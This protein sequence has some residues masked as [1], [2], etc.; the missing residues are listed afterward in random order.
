M[1][2]AELELVA[3]VDVDAL[4][5]DA[6]ESIV[7]SAPRPVAGGIILLDDV[8]DKAQDIWGAV[9][10]LLNFLSHPGGILGWLRDQVIN[11]FD[12]VGAARD[13]LWRAISDPFGGLAQVVSGIVGWLWN[14]IR[15]SSTGVLGW[16]RDA[17]DWLWDRISDP[18]G[19][20][21]DFVSGIVGWLWNQIRN[22]STGVLAWIRDARDWLWDRIS[23]PFG[24][25]AQFVSGIVGWLW[26]HI[27][28][29]TT[30]VLGWIRDARHWLWDRVSDPVT[31][32]FAWVANRALWLWDLTRAAF[33]FMGTEFARAFTAVTTTIIDTSQTVIRETGNA[34]IAGAQGVGEFFQSGLDWLFNSVFEPFAD[35]IAVKASI[36]R[37]LVTG[38]Y[39]T[40]EQL[41]DDIEDPLSPSSILGGLSM[42]SMMSIALPGILSEVGQ[43]RAQRLIQDAAALQGATIPSFTDLRD[44][45][46]RRVMSRETHDDWLKRAGFSQANVDVIH[47]LYFDLPT[48][49]DL[50]RMAVREVFTPDV[51]SRFGLFDE[52]PADFA[53][54]AEQIG[55]SRDWA[56]RHWGAHWELPSVQQGF[57]MFHRDV[58]DEGTLDLLLRTKDVMPFWRDKLRA[59]TYSTVTRVDIRRLYHAGVVDRP[60]V[61]RVYLDL[62]Y[63]PDDAAA[64]TEFV[65]RDTAGATTDL[66]REVIESAYEDRLL[67]REQAAEALA[68]HRFSPEHIDL[69]LDRVDV[70]VEKHLAALAERIVERDVKAGAIGEA[71][72]R[73]QLE[74]LGVPDA[75]IDLLLDFWSRE[76]AVKDRDLTPAQL[77]RLFR[78]E[79]ISDV[80]LRDRL[81]RQGYSD[82]DIGYLIALSSP[83]EAPPEPREL[84]KADLRAA[85]RTGVLAETDVRG[86]LG[87]AG[88]VTADIDVLLSTWEAA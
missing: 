25:V 79:I 14:Q 81:G 57:E 59:I 69:F 44:A 4:L 28:H 55:I 73:S 23:D 80:T 87:D 29:P 1:E 72:A 78:S 34:V 86:R 30:G 22:S 18:F 83:E 71:A 6:I 63:T 52:F 16:T 3:P 58:V 32:I 5:A 88:Y 13:W 68:D 67:T 84:T 26:D 41:M 62:G 82:T 19:A 9:R 35:A 17:R 60:R 43:I 85:L 74:E 31:G 51:I 53:T 49:S 11:I 54:W 27:K 47:A 2:F 8:W 42:I 40:I 46:L 12:A 24:G 45:F 76:A 64:L 15:N 20:V 66:P 65:V 70:R 21:A 61:E 75:R 38:G 36:P 48:P 37:K 39:D 7:G 50:V 33:V 56:E 77:L 10:Q